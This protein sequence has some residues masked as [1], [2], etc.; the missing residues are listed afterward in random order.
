MC[1]SPGIATHLLYIRHSCLR[2]CES[3]LYGMVSLMCISPGIATHLLYIRHSCL[4]SCESTLYGMTSLMRISPGIA[5]HLLYIHHSW[6]RSLKAQ[7]SS[8]KLFCDSHGI[9][10]MAFAKFFDPFYENPYHNL[11]CVIVFKLLGVRA[12]VRITITTSP[13]VAPTSDPS[14]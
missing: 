6:L 9:G 8:N 3:T 13:Q 4:R 10:V 7:N 5:T 12:V 1:I 14:P 11:N 2:S